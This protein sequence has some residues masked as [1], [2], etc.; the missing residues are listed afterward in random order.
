MT[1]ADPGLETEQPSRLRRAFDAVPVHPGS[2][3][4][5]LLERNTEAWSARWHLL[6]QA[7]T[8][9]SV[10]YFILQKDIFGF[11]FL[12]H[13]LKK[14]REG[15]TVRLMTDAVADTFGTHGFKA[16]FRGQ[17]FLQELVESGVA[18]RVYHPL[19]SRPWR[20]LSWGWMAS[21]HDKILVCDG[22]RSITGGRNIGWDYFASPEDY[23]EA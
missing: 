8:S 4:V 21:N 9:I 12:G 17:D 10:N 18:V 20:I 14:A 7:T 15:C 23:P 16:T 19:Y 2:A 3:T 22:T 1:P 6:E 13:L 5:R 11:A